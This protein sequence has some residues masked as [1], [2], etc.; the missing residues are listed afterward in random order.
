[1]YSIYLIG[2]SEFFDNPKSLVEAT[3]QDFDSWVARQIHIQWAAE[4]LSE[5]HYRLVIERRPHLPSGPSVMF[6]WL[7]LE[8][9]DPIAATL[10]RLVGPTPYRIS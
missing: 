7:C 9:T 10:Y 2:L 4:N 6:S 3:G 5:N 1:M 8:I